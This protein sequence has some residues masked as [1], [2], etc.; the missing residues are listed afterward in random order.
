M[1]TQPTLISLKEGESTLK[2]LREQLTRLGKNFSPENVVVLSSNKA[3]LQELVTQAGFPV[4]E[5]D[6]PRPGKFRWGT[7]QAFKGMEAPAI[8]LVEFEDGSAA[9]R[10]TFYV[11]GTRAIAELV[12]II[13]Q[14]VIKSLF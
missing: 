8:V 13:P 14:N 10:E 3:K 6:F 11:A 2:H 7:S 5:L 1:G 4:T 9:T 12:C